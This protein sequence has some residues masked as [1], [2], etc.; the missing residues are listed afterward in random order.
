MTKDKRFSGKEEN[1]ERWAS[2]DIQEVNDAR[3][4]DYIRKD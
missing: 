3:L 4:M 2:C 1:Y